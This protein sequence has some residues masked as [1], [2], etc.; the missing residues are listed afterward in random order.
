ML[1]DLIRLADKLDSKGLRK[2]A[3]A[4]DDIIKEATES[5]L[6]VLETEERMA[7]ERRAWE[8]RN[9]KSL[10]AE[11]WIAQNLYVGL[12][13]DMKR[14][15]ITTEKD[16]VFGEAHFVPKGT[17]FKNLYHHINSSVD[18]NNNS[19]SLWDLV[20]A[21]EENRRNLDEQKQKLDRG[22]SALW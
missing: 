20:Q 11:T 2:E 4:L 12:P 19:V 5:T 3:N 9:E 18:A 14:F 22:E 8:K 10:E 17:K 15:P 7:T 6:D 16:L 13:D 21:T 1:R